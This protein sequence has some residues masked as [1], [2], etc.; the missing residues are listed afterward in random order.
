V[1]RSG[2]PDLK[3][4][5]RTWLSLAWFKAGRGHETQRGVR[6]EG[7]KPVSGGR[8]RERV[9]GRWCATEPWRGLAGVHWKKG[10]TRVLTRGSDGVGERLIP[11]GNQRASQ[12][13]A[14]AW[15]C[16]HDGRV[17]REKRRATNS[18]EQLGRRLTWQNVMHSKGERR[19]GS[20]LLL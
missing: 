8:A 2:A 12:Q 20:R 11:R 4:A 5:A 9:T 18:A 7:G 3:L 14:R 19:K 1:A 16:S 17:R 6:G 15:S 10:R 13:R